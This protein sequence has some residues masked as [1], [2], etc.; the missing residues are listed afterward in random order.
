MKGANQMKAIIFL[1]LAI[2][3]VLFGY[4]MWFVQN[5]P[6]TAACFFILSMMCKDVSKESEE[7]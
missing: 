5:E 4:W 1:L 7:P 2:V 3:S 6:A